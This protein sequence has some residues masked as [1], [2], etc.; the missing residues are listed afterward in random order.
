MYRKHKSLAKGYVYGLITKNIK[1][2][3]PN[4]TQWSE[5]QADEFN[6]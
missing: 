3:F 1:H 2:I 4:G 6:P 5:S